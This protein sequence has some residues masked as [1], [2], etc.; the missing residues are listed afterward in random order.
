MVLT[1]KIKSLLASLLLCSAFSSVAQPFECN[2]DYFLS[3][4]ANG[5]SIIYRVEIDPITNNV[6]F[7]PLS[8]GN[9]GAVVNAV[10]FRATDNYIYGV[11]PDNHILYRIDASGTATMLATLTDLNSDFQ[12]FAGEIDASGNF[13]YLLG[14]GGLPY[15]T[16][17]F[18][19]VNLDDYSLSTINIPNAESAA[20]FIT[21]FS[22]DPQT[23]DLYGFDRNDNR[24]VIINPTTGA[25][26]ENSFPTTQVSD[27]MG[28][29]F[30]DAFG[31]LFGYGDQYNTMISNTLFRIDKNTGIVT[32]EAV[33]PTAVGKDGCAC[34]Y[35]VELQKTVYP[36]VAF[37]CTEVTYVFEIANASA[38]PV[39]EATFSD[40]MP[41]AFTI[42][43]IVSNPFG[44]TIVSG[45]GSSIINIQDM[46]IPQGVDSIVVRVEI[47]ED[48]EG[49]YANQAVL[50]NLPGALGSETFSD[51]PETLFIGDST[52]IEVVPLFIDLEN[53]TL[54]LC[55][56]NTLELDASTHGVTYLWHDGSTN[57]IYQAE[58]EGLYWVEV[59][60]GCETVSDSIYVIENNLEIDLGPDI[61]INLGDSVFMDPS[62]LGNASLSWTDPLESS[63]SCLSCPNPSARP[64][65]D[66]QYILAGSDMFGCL[67]IDSIQVSVNKSREIFIPNVF[68]PN[69]DG[70]N[71]VF[72][73]QGRGFGVI[74]QF[75]IFDRWGK[76][77]YSAAKGNINDPDIGWD[78]RTE[79]GFYNNAVFVY[80]VEIEYLDGVVEV[81]SGDITLIR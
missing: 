76:Q 16:R 29:I 72:F 2:G 77:V 48:A 56:G 80:F 36:E 41:E 6:L 38:I 20:A 14:S 68:S 52:L 7:N 15:L 21:D 62:I 44:G 64:F 3:L 54:F 26:D 12:Y 67:S 46:E 42:T 58:G 65:F 9:S 13:L 25:I 51:D 59:E 4:T 53:D 31:N 71:D 57:A 24:L 66:V 10:G 8:A 33:G 81:F 17:T 22:F 28:A 35:T 60:S 23:G 37:P 32:Q 70:F 30:F 47:D 45:V 43:E 73:V 11:D 5:P 63:L 74:Q 50:S 49:F 55:T 40:V 61:E 19:K 1:V 27:A 34:P 75:Q 78:G 18:I 79:N 39:T 69:G